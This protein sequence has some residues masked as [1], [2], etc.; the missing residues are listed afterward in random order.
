MNNLLSLAG[1]WLPHTARDNLTFSNQRHAMFMDFM[2]QPE[3]FHQNPLNSF[4]EF[5]EGFVKRFGEIEQLDDIY[6]VSDEI[7]TAKAVLQLAY[8]EIMDGPDI[9]VMFTGMFR[10]GYTV[11]N[12]IA[13]LQFVSNEY[14]L[15]VHDVTVLE[16]FGT[17]MFSGLNA[18]NAFV[19][20]GQL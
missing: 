4:I 16:L 3:I 20:F 9:H 15:M 1:S 11:K 17:H 18:N 6:I 2:Q 12:L 14:F 13:F 10:A 8:Y 5:G 7:A 19:K